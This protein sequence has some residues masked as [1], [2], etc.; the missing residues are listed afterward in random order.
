MAPGHGWTILPFAAL[1][2]F[3]LYRRYRSHVGPQRIKPRRMLL[4]PVLLGALGVYILATSTG[5]QAWLAMAAGLAAG[6]GL[7]LLSLRHTRF[8]TREARHY[9]IPNIYIGLAVSALFVLRIVWRLL[10]IYPQIESGSSS[11]LAALSAAKSLPTLAL[12][13]LVIGYYVLYYIGV[14]MLSRRAVAALSA[15]TAE[16]G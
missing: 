13:G 14:L 7:A 11:P 10:V 15:A 12:L 6:A 8:E 16:A 4:R 3:S 9:Y 5:P 2:L 1:I